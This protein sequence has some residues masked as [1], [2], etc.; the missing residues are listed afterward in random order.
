M[1]DRLI[2]KADIIGIEGRSFRLKEAQERT[3]RRK[4]RRTGASS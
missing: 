3:A 4:A 2:H 1:I